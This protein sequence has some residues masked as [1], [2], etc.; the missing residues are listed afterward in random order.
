MNTSRSITPPTRPTINTK[1]IKDLS[2]HLNDK[3]F[4]MYNDMGVLNCPPAPPPKTQEIRECY[5]C[6]QTYQIE[7]INAPLKKCGYCD[8]H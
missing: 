8:N 6:K 1:I 3:E 5:S 2:L 4:P 7:F